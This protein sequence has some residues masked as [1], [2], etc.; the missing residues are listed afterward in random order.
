MKKIIHTGKAKRCYIA[1]IGELL[2]HPHVVVEFK[3]KSA[4][5]V[6]EK[7]ET[8]VPGIYHYLVTST[9]KIMVHQEHS[10]IIIPAGS[11]I[12]TQVEYNVITKLLDKVRD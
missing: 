10:P 1:E 5:N 11:I 2:A 7:V 12:S 8:D 3:G 9:I 6:L 4:K